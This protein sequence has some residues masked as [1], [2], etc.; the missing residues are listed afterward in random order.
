MVQTYM[1]LKNLMDTVLMKLFKYD[2][3]QETHCMTVC[4]YNC[5]NST[6]CFFSPFI[7]IPHFLFLVRK[8]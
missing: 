6:E 4:M 1:L 2:L 7:V 3:A 5:L 8:T